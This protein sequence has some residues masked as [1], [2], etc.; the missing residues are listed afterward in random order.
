MDD[1]Q[2]RRI[3]K[4]KEE[5]LQGRPE[6]FKSFGK[7]E[8]EAPNPK[9]REPKQ[10]GEKVTEVKKTKKDLTKQEKKAIK[11]ERKKLIRE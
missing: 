5:K 8:G 3:E 1:R 4:R 10:E 6:S 9:V 7:P 11:L 2:I